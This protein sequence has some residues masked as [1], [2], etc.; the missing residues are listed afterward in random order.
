M[1]K[2]VFIFAVFVFSLVFILKDRL[3]DSAEIKTEKISD[4]H[5]SAV[6]A[7]QSDMYRP[8][9]FRYQKAMWFTSMDYADIMKDRSEKEFSEETEKRFK[10]A[11]LSGMNTVYVQ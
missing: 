1:K 3:P 6:N 10:N 8:L 7:V 11:V 2:A 5:V 9:N 4:N